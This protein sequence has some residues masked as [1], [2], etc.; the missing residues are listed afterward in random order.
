MIRPIDLPTVPAVEPVWTL[1]AGAIVLFTLP[2]W[3]RRMACRH[4]ATANLIASDG[5]HFGE[6]PCDR[7]TRLFYPVR[8]DVALEGNRSAF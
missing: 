4:E 3:A 7:Q 2:S 8:T 1:G 5:T 6:L